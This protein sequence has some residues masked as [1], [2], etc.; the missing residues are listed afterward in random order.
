M[1]VRERYGQ[2]IVAL[3]NKS[4]LL[5]GRH[6][7]D[8]SVDDAQ[9]RAADSEGDGEARAECRVNAVC[10][11]HGT[12]RWHSFTSFT[13]PLKG[14]P[15]WI[16]SGVS[17]GEEEHS[18]SLSLLYTQAFCKFVQLVDVH[19][20]SLLPFRQ[21][22][23][24]RSPRSLHLCELPGAFLLALMHSLDP[25]QSRALQWHINGLN[26]HWEWASPPTT[27][28][29]C[30]NG[31]M[32]D[33]LLVANECAAAF[34]WSGA[35]DVLLDKEWD[36]AYLAYRFGIVVG[37]D[38]EE[39][40]NNNKF[41]LVTA[42]GGFDCANNPSGQELLMLPLIKHQIQIACKCLRRGGTLLLKT[43]TFFD[44]ETVA[45]IATLCAAFGEVRCTKPPSSKP[46]NSEVYLICLDFNRT[47]DVQPVHFDQSF[48][49]RIL[50][51]ARTLAGHQ[52][53]FIEFNLATFRRL[54]QDERTIICIEKCSAVERWGQRMLDKIRPAQ[55]PQMAM[56][57][58]LTPPSRW[59]SWHQ[60][61][62]P[63]NVDKI[64]RLTEQQQQRQQNG[65][66]FEFPPLV[67]EPNCE[68]IFAWLQQ[69]HSNT[70]DAAA[71][72][73]IN[74]NGWSAGAGIVF[75]R[76]D[77]PGQRGGTHRIRHSLFAH[78]DWLK[79]AQN[80][81][82]LC[83]EGQSLDGDNESTGK[84]I[85]QRRL[86]SKLE[87]L[88]FLIAQC[89][90][91]SSTNASILEL[92]LGRSEAI[93]QTFGHDGCAKFSF[94][95]ANTPNVCA[96][97]CRFLAKL[98][99]AF[100]TRATADHRW[101]LLKFVPLRFFDMPTTTAATTTT[102]TGAKDWDGHGNGGR[103][104]LGEQIAEFNARSIALSSATLSSCATSEPS[105][106]LLLPNDDLNNGRHTPP[107]S[108][109]GE[110]QPNASKKTKFADS[111]TS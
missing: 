81:Q 21:C 90:L 34:G 61:W 107:S 63:K 31:V 78:P 100:K 83:A 67:F 99:T 77:D 86:S 28:S 80:V 7:M 5:G 54:S 13:H 102:T 3:G 6:F 76:F 71:D 109:K 48:L 89:E 27:S 15:V 98:F 51:A 20:E 39:N 19:P 33:V 96:A 69:H 12:N 44:R 74:D 18:S 73:G 26:P 111:E 4:I 50:E 66:I 65:K 10:A 42:D 30:S 60:I 41:D 37:Q 58:S 22:Q 43:F 35:G 47:N 97:L 84:S 82:D 68:E 46:G 62:H 103:R 85:G 53:G 8:K 9:K 72:D 108:S 106:P 38:E 64:C 91:V 101:T 14:L 75:G 25:E 56:E 95:Q 40:A 49:K 57:L 94:S 88:E 93:L 11:R 24:H 59:C 105:P 87:W 1:D 16:A 32:D 110:M 36:D 79:Q 23:T 29:S 104:S 2:L 70:T 52:I 55:R 17:V 92:K 45:L